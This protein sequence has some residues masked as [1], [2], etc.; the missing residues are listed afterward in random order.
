MGLEG[1]AEPTQICEPNQTARPCAELV[2]IG[3]VSKFG[4]SPFF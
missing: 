2:V 3:G 1:H 4:M